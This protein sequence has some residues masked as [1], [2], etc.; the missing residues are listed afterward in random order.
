M[1]ETRNYTTYEYKEVTIDKAKASLY[2]D[3]YQSFGWQTNENFAPTESMGKITFKLKRDRKLVN[4]VELTRLQ[5]HF[6][7]DAADILA[8]ERSKTAMAR[9]WALVI[10]ILGTAFMAGSVFAVTANPPIIWLCIIL[11]VPGF[12]GWIAPYFVYGF[13]K[14]KKTRQVTPFIEEKTE[15]IYNLCEKGQS[16]L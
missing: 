10:G 6:E 1:S 13:L 14:Q 8:M 15:E 3:A 9:V 4:R 5:N 7:A 11:A 16:L 2:L 12:I